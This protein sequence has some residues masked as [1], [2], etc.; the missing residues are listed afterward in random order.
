MRLTGQY[1]FYRSSYKQVM[2][3]IY[4]YFIYGYAFKII[5]DDCGFKEENSFYCLIELSDYLRNGY[6]LI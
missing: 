1:S 3:P 4:A 5:I 6:K 2:W